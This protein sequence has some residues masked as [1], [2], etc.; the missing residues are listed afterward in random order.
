[1][2][3]NSIVPAG[4]RTTQYP[5]LLFCCLIFQKWPWLCP[6][7]AHDVPYASS[8]FLGQ[9]YDRILVSEFTIFA[10]KW[11]KIAGEKKGF[12]VFANH[13]AVHSGKISRGKEFFAPELLSAHIERFSVSCIQVFLPWPTMAEFLKTI[14]T[15]TN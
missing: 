13:P 9:I 7:Q 11:S 1:M 4:Q 5:L 14:L 8:Y 3:W 15:L 2:D 6:R 12:W 10:Q